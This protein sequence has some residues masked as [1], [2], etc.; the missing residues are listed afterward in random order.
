MKAEI[1]ELEAKGDRLVS[2]PS[3]VSSG[4]PAALAAVLDGESQDAELKALDLDFDLH[5][6]VRKK[7]AVKDHQ[8][9]QYE[10]SR[11]L[12]Q[13]VNHELAYFFDTFGYERDDNE[14]EG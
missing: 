14:K 9:K 1:K 2:V 8:T 10:H 7:Y 12:I 3:L 4:T 6:E 11:E 13:R 5:P